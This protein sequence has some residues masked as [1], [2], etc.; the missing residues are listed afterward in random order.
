VLA[1]ANQKGIRVI[2]PFIDNWKWWGGIPAMAAFRDKQ[3]GDFWTDD[4]LFED[5][6]DIVRYVVNRTNTITGVQYKTI[7]PSSR[8]KPVTNWKARTNG[9]PKPRPL[10]KASIQSPCH[11]RFP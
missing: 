9:R 8:G 2:I 6:K 5:Y 10:S 11:R 4:Q 3:A 1:I 7:K